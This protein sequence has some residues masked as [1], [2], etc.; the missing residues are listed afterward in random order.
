MTR[1]T[2]AI[3]SAR[4][5][6]KSARRAL[7]PDYRLAASNTIADR[8]VRMHEFVACKKFACYLPMP[9]EVDATAVIER[10]WRMQ[11]DVYA[12]VIDQHGGMAFVRLRPDTALNRNWY[13]LWEPESGAQIHAQDIDLV[14]TPVV[15]FDKHRHRIGMGSAYF[16]R[17]FA[18]LKHKQYWRRPKLVGLA[19]NCQQ[20]E[21]IKPNPWD[22][23]LY[24]VITEHF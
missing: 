3:A 2:D 12:P 18:F 23:P 15:A 9:D 7:S 1:R 8:V 21:K 5:A 11:K 17:C 16:D 4:R 6:A 22:I 20:V 19:F 10:A 14:I 24:K 13:G